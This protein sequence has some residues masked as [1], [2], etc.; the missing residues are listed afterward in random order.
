MP[1]QHALFRRQRKALNWSADES[2]VVL[3][4]WCT[5]PEIHHMNWPARI[6]L[7]SFVVIKEY[8]KSRKEAKKTA[9]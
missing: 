3:G 9:V 2:Q 5:I 8:G 1:S 4:I 7:S 6:I